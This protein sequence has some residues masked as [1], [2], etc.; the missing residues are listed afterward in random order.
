MPD[1]NYTLIVVAL[2]V[3]FLL[4]NSGNN[5]NLIRKILRLIILV[6][7]LLVSSSPTQA[8][9]N[10]GKY[11]QVG[12]VQATDQDAGSELVYT[13]TA[14]NTGSYFKI[15]PCSGILTV[16]TAAYTTFTLQRTWYITVKSADMEGNFVKTTGK[17]VLKKVA[18]VKVKPTLLGL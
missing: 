8:Q 3:I 17:I 9:F 11:W 18:G 2:L 1:L 12:F 15:T 10:P 16:D 4:A 6:V 13:I 5:I 14:G 7:V